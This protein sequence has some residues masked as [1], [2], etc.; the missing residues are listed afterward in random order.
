[1]GR[2]HAAAA[3]EAITIAQ[4]AVI[5]SEATRRE[6]RQTTVTDEDWRDARIAGVMTAIY[7][8]MLLG[9]FRAA[10][11]GDFT[12]TNPALETL[13]GWPPRT[14]HEFA[15]GGE[16]DRMPIAA[17]EGHPMPPCATFP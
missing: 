13:L 11:L 17:P 9:M 12:A 6:V 14:M 16:V 1:M 10:R 5:V 2:H 4:L 7:A 8:D 15:L 3:T